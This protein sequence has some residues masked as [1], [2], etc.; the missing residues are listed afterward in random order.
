[1]FSLTSSPTGKRSKPGPMDGWHLKIRQKKNLEETVHDTCCGKDMLQNQWFWKKHCPNVTLENVSPDKEKIL[2]SKGG[3][4][5]KSYMCGWE[6]QR[7]RRIGELEGWKSGDRIE[8]GLADVL[9]KS[10]PILI[11][12]KTCD[13]EAHQDHKEKVDKSSTCK[14]A[15]LEHKECRLVHVGTCDSVTVVC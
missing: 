2:K 4:Q 6:T 3:T 13:C 11:F 5:S 1:M 8:F 9:P 7:K 14:T 12:P 15:S 10:T